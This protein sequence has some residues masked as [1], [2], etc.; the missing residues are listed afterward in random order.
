[1]Y[2]GSATPCWW[3][4]GGERRAG[5]LARSA[6]R[7]LSVRIGGGEYGRVGAVAGGVVGAVAGAVVGVVGGGELKKASMSHFSLLGCL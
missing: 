5:Q 2:V 3:V 4:H 6:Q 7:G 1:M